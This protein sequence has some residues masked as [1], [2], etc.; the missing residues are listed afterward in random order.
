MHGPAHPGVA[1]VLQGGSVQ[2]TDDRR[3]VH[4]CPGDH[5]REPHPGPLWYFRWTNT[6]GTLKSLSL[7]TPSLITVQILLCKVREGKYL[8]PTIKQY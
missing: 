6:A 7:I 8:L 2:Q 4:G 1:A 3:P 5:H